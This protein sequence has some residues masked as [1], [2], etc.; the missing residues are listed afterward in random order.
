MALESIEGWNGARCITRQPT[1]LCAKWEY[2]SWASG[3]KWQGSVGNQSIFSSPF[4]A[5]L[6]PISAALSSLNLDLW[7]Q[8]DTITTPSDSGLLVMPRILS[9]SNEQG[10]PSSE[11]LAMGSRFHRTMALPHCH[12]CANAGDGTVT[13]LLQFSGGGKEIRRKKKNNQKKN[14]KKTTC[15]GLINI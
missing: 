2:Q 14:Q 1:E 12:P 11:L 9:P 15:Q 8:V 7:W 5:K 6:S 4:C 13:S 3:P 10:N